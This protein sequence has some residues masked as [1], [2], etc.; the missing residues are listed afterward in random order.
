MEQ[1]IDQWADWWLEN[2]LRVSSGVKWGVL[3][4]AG[5][6]FIYFLTQFHWSTLT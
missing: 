2:R 1:K 6:G 5:C 4:L 3:L